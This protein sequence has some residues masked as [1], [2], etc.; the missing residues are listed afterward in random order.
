MDGRGLTIARGRCAFLFRFRDLVR[1][2]RKTA[3]IASGFRGVNGVFRVEIRAAKT[4][5]TAWAQGQK[6]RHHLGL[7]RV[8]LSIKNT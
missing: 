8:S 1:H 4:L 5:P 6:L 3:A 2:F 7:I